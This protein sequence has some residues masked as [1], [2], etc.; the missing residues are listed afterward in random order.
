MSPLSS[1][2]VEAI[3]MTKDRLLNKVDTLFDYGNKYK[4][5]KTVSFAWRVLIHLVGDI[6]QP[7]HSTALCSKAFPHGDKGGNLF[8][9]KFNGNKKIKNLHSL[10]DSCLGQQT[11]IRVPLNAEDWQLLTESV[12]NITSTYPR[13]AVQ[14]R[15]AILDEQEWANESYDLAV[16]FVYNGTVAYKEQ[17]PEY[18]SRGRMVIN[19]Q[20]AVAGYRLA[21]LI[22][23]LKLDYKIE[24]L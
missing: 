23:S 21:D 8:K 4:F 14:Q 13:S 10:W 17:L 9:I 11:Q 3:K 7:L 5:T 1:N 6:H 20:L 15:V 16:K 18:I 24:D 12:E 2:I 22:L 19:E